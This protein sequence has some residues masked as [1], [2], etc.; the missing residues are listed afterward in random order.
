M[1]PNLNGTLESSDPANRELANLVDQKLDFSRERLFIE[2]ASTLLA[3]VPGLSL[4]RAVAERHKM[5]KFVQLVLPQC[6]AHIEAHARNLPGLD[7]GFLDNLSLADQILISVL[8]L[9]DPSTVEHCVDVCALTGWFSNCELC[10]KGQTASTPLLVARASLLHDGGKPELPSFLLECPLDRDVQP[11]VYCANVADRR[12]VR[13]VHAPFQLSAEEQETFGPLLRAEDFDPAKIKAFMNLCK[14]RRG[15]FRKMPA[16]FLLNTSREILAK[17][18]YPD[19]IHEYMGREL[20]VDPKVMH[21]LSQQEGA[22]N[23]MNQVFDRYGIDGWDMTFWDTLTFHERMVVMMMLVQWDRFVGEENYS[24]DFSLI[25]LVGRHHAYPET[26]KVMQ[27][28]RQLLSHPME[29]RMVV[30]A[31]LLKVAD[32]AAALAQERPY[33]PSTEPR[34]TVADIDK[35][36]GFQRQTPELAA[37]SAQVRAAFEGAN[38]QRTD[39]L[40]V[41]AENLGVVEE[42]EE[43]T[44]IFV[45]PGM[46]DSAMHS[47]FILQSEEP[48]SRQIVTLSD[49]DEEKTKLFV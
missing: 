30:L 22:L 39:A 10:S 4:I 13:A 40:Q 6:R 44:R 45:V 15:D 42:S 47:P 12:R 48:A 34:K 46:L 7:L 26:Q 38:D 18:E 2:S 5:D 25:H 49:D 27:R 9:K 36:L 8:F 3:E 1:A 16:R 11:A 41:I 33:R 20:Q 29:E 37:V 31:A 43:E 32:I 35:I 28:S 19:S 23:N 14:M 17:G 24:P 21:F